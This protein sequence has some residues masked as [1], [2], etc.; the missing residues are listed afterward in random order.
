[1]WINLLVAHCQCD[2]PE[3]PACSPLPILLL[4]FFVSIERHGIHCELWM[5][6]GVAAYKKQL[7]PCQLPDRVQNTWQVTCVDKHPLMNLADIV[8]A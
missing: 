5:P 4:E 6:V 3:G 8:E 2:Y 7:M 1:M